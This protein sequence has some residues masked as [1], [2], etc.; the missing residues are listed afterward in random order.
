MTTPFVARWLTAALLVA[1]PLQTLDDAARGWVLAHR[2]PALESAMRVVS[3][4]SRAVLIGGAALAALSGAAGRAFALEAAIAVVP[5]NLAVETLK[6][7]V[8][9][10]RPDGDQN[11]RNSSFPSSHAAN[12][13]TVAAVLAR[14]W[15]RAALPAFLAAAVV[16]YSRMVLDRHWL[17][18]VLG[19]L[20]LALAGAW[21]AAWVL[22]RWSERKAVARTS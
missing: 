2:T 18:D 13:F 11:R 3:G 7:T 12:A 10:T 17:S 22:R 5:V 9:R 1:W 14:R 6:W 8:A 15:R 19:G 21:L 20:V 4:K 16:A